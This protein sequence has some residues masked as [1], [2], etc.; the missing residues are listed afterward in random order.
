MF[1]AQIELISIWLPATVHAAVSTA[2]RLV[3]NDTA[4]NGWF[5]AATSGHITEDR[6]LLNTELLVLEKD[7]VVSL[8][9]PRSKKRKQEEMRKGSD[10]NLEFRL[11][12][13]DAARQSKY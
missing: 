12:V 4:Y 6:P 10:S 13:W 9:E 11:G 5:K 3:D 7:S 8:E 1:N 2:R